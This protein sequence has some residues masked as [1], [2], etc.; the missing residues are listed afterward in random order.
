MHSK[1]RSQQD[2]SVAASF[3]QHY[4]L[5]MGTS[6]LGEINSCY[7]SLSSDRLRWYLDEIEMARSYDSFC[8][9]ES[10]DPT[11]DGSQNHELAVAFLERYFPVAAPW[12]TE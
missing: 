6:I 4:G 10:G 11:A 2:I 12:E 9:N 5:A 7:V 3:A 1:F 8:I